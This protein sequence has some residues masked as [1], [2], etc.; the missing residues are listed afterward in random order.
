MSSYVDGTT[1]V[2]PLGVIEVWDG[3][4]QRWVTKDQY[5]DDRHDTELPPDF[6]EKDFRGCFYNMY[7]VDCY[8]SM[9]YSFSQGEDG[10]NLL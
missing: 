9:L 8:A 4:R 5:Y 3:F 1:K 2:S 7:S 6:T 10:L